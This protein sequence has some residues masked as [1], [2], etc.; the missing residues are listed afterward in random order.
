MA[1]TISASGTWTV[2]NLDTTSAPQV[3]T[4]MNVP[5]I[6]KAQFEQIKSAGYPELMQFIQLMA[7]G[8]G[9]GFQH[10]KSLCFA[11]LTAEMN[12]ESPTSRVGVY[13]P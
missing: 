6:S 10:A 4:G 1:A 12:R 11:L 3:K 9:I 2:L 7:D 8:L 13:A 5:G